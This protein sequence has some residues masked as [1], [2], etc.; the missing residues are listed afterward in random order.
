MYSI[1]CLTYSVHYLVLTS[2]TG[3]LHF[4]LQ[5]QEL[6]DLPSK[7]T[8]LPAAITKLQVAS[9]LMCLELIFCIV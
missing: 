4:M 3:D 2:L 1:S 8:G 5:V 7:S 9:G 6:L